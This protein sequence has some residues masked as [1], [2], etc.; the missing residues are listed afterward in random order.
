M[1]RNSIVTRTLLF[2]YI[3]PQRELV[4]EMFNVKDGVSKGGSRYNSWGEASAL[5]ACSLESK[6]KCVTRYGYQK[7]PSRGVLKKI[8]LKLCSKFTGEHL[9]RSVVSI[10]LLCNF[11][12]IALRHGFSP[13]NILHI[14]RAPL[15]GC[16]CPINIA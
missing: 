7:Q 4:K 2:V 11:I 3:W 13:V 5:N 16:F 8:V 9:C 10:T 15:D 12:E 1:L 6:V 14:I